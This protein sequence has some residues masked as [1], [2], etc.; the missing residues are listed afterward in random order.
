MTGI[1]LL[2]TGLSG[3]GKSTLVSEVLKR[4]QNLEYLKTYTTRPMRLGEESSH[5][6]IFVSQPE[7]D[8]LQAASPR[9][10]HTAYNGFSYGADVKNIYHSLKSGTNIVCCV[11]PDA[12]IVSLVRDTYHAETVIIMID[13]PKDVAIAR[14]A[15]DTQRSARKEEIFGMVV[16]YTF[17]PTENLSADIKRFHKLITTITKK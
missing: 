5:E 10:D 12:D 17:K 6:Y 8:Q 4:I 16:D 3:S 2:V 14:I 9:W 11:A 7:Y 1:L 13:T 15:Q